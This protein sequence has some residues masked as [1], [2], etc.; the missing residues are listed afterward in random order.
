MKN[1]IWLDECSRGCAL[2]TLTRARMIEAEVASGVRQPSHDD[3][4]AVGPTD[5]DAVM[6]CWAVSAV[7]RDL[8][9]VRGLVGLDDL[10]A[11]GARWVMEEAGIYD[12][13]EYS[14]APGVDPDPFE[15]PAMDI[16][17][18]GL[19]LDLKDDLL[20]L[21]VRPPAD[22]GVRLAYLR[23][24]SRAMERDMAAVGGLPVPRTAIALAVSRTGGD[25]MGLRMMSRAIAA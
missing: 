11:E 17:S 13:P 3:P 10:I 23:W 6:Q 12:A 9:C 14:V 16:G 15:R 1:P 25:I 18:L 22:G 7:E 21:G 2:G 24:V 19:A 20:R 4:F 5:D 8:R